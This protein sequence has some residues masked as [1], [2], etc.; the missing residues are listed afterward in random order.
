MLAPAKSLEQMSRVVLNDYINAG[1]CAI[2]MFVV[3][4]TVTFGIRAAR[5]AENRPTSRETP[6]EPLPSAA[7]AG[8]D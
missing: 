1:L 6:Y 7:A 3:I 2:F 4:S 5:R 8:A